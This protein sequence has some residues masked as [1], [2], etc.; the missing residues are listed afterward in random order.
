M[1][2]KSMSMPSHTKFGVDEIKALRLRQDFVVDVPIRKVITQIEVRKPNKQEFFRVHPDESMQFE[3]AI[4]EYSIEK[5]VY[6]VAPEILDK[7]TNE[8]VP[9]VLMFCVT[10]QGTPFLWPIKLPSAEGAI[11]NWNCTAMDAAILARS[12]WVRLI[13][14]G[15]G[16]EIQVAEVNSSAPEFPHLTLEEVLTLAFEKRYIDDLSHPVVRKLRGVE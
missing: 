6:L 4:L 5:R 13:P 16:Y 9:K 11:D 15:G 7:L 14:R 2:N 12:E 3:S 8:V 1:E 10:K